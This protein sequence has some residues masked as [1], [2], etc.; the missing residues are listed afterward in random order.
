MAKSKADEL[1]KRFS[2]LEEH[3]RNYE[4]TWDQITEFVLPHR[5]DFMIKRAKGQRRD[6]RLFDTTAIQSNEF[7]ASTLHGGLTNPSTKWFELKSKKPVLNTIEPVQQFLEIGT[8]LIFDIIN[9]PESN[10]Q[11]QNHELFLDLVA[12]GT[13]CMFIEEV[14]GEGITF[15]AVHLSEIFVAEDKRGHIDT[16]FRKFKFTAR[17][18]AQFWGE[19]KLPRKMKRCLQDKPDEMFDIIHCVK[20]NSEVDRESRK[21][22]KLPYVSYYVALEDKEIID[23]S[24]FHEMPYLVPRW[25][26]LIGETYGRSPAWSALADIR[27][28]NVMSKS[29]LVATEK[30]V[31]PPL[32]MADD[33]VMLPLRTAPGGI[34]FGGLDINGQA[35]IQPLPGPGRIDVGMQMLEDRAK[36]IRNAYFI[37]PLLMREGPQMTA[38]EVLQR[39]EEK[40]R[41]VGPQIGR[42]QTEYLNPL[43][44][45]LYGILQRNGALPPLPDEVADLIEQGGLDI[46]YTAPL[47]RTQRGNEPIAL[48][49]TLEAFLP[50]VQI[51]PAIMD[52]I[53]LDRSMKQVA[54]ILGVPMNMMNTEE[55][56]QHIRQQRQQQMEQAQQMQMMNEGAQRVAELTKAGVFNEG[57]E[58]GG[59]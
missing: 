25:A 53:N 17:Q 50:L 10:F 37:D 14:P 45:R 47:A 16:V 55:E 12:Y 28:I 35:R 43:I 18:A 29:L 44:Q 34:N 22:T 40:L 4:N 26:K 23:I 57:E 32:L 9:S 59:Q 54:E 27:L 8:N 33:G 56:K 49:R 7:L 6:R 24:G 5:G 58:G 42:I 52:N 11:S 36:A 20:P 31:D 13:A 51:D 15:K 21:N 38:T 39:Q 46:E 19:D 3:R 41:L 1:I 30:A 48:Q 2:T